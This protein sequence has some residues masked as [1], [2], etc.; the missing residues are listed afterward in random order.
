VRLQTSKLAYRS[1]GM[2]LDFNSCMITSSKAILPIFPKIPLAARLK[3][4]LAYSSE[5]LK[6]G[7]RTIKIPK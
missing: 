7:A 1:S 2:H 3:D 4:R 6:T 5:H